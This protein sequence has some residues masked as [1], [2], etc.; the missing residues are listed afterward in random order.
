MGPGAGYWGLQ[1]YE[2]ARFLSTI[3]RSNEAVSYALKDYVYILSLRHRLAAYGYEV[4]EEI[5]GL[6]LE[7]A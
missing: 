1:Q 5:L 4:L 3:D 7:V 2:R 6:F